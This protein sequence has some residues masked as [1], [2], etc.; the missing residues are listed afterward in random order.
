MSS[1]KSDSLRIEF[2]IVA[3]DSQ[4]IIYLTILGNTKHALRLGDNNSS[5]LNK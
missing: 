1:I 5:C 2:K 4:I 3:L